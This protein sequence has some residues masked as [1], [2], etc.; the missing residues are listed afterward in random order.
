MIKSIKP[1]V[2]AGKKPERIAEL[3]SQHFD[4]VVEYEPYALKIR[5]IDDYKSMR[6]LQTHTHLLDQVGSVYWSCD[7]VGPFIGLR[8]NA[9]AIDVIS[10]ERARRERNSKVLTQ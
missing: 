7:A 6:V 2:L 3:L 1:G 10:G 4:C 8:F 9:I 5:C